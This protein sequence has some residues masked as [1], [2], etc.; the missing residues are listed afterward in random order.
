[1]KTF[2]SYSS[3]AT[4][5]FGYDMAKSLIAHRSSPRGALVLALR[6][7]LGTGKTTFTQGFFRGLGIQQNP[8]SPTFVI[9]RRYK[10]PGRRF[11][12][13]Y[14]FDAY[15]LKRAED[16]AMLEFGSI[17]SDPKNIII[18]EWPEQIKK[19]LPKRTL[20]LGFKYGKKENERTIRAGNLSLSRPKLP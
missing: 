15:R 10:I 12:D 17:L 18:V 2:H 6:G 20:W 7:D 13:V 5:V 14:H 3:E 11:A 4:K 16:V 9:M 19:V 1:M 8:V